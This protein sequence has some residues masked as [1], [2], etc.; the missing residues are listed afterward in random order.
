MK[1]SAIMHA[2]MIGTGI[3]G[4]VAL[5]GGWLASGSGAF[6]GI[7]AGLFYTNAMNLQLVA[8]SAGICTIVRRNIEKENPGSFL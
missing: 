3:L 4:G 2:V 8:I 5:I 6:L 7:P 1:Y